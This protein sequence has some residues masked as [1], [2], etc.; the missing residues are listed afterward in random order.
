MNTRLLKKA[1]IIT[2]SLIVLICIASILIMRCSGGNLNAEIIVDGKVLQTV[3]LNSIDAPFTVITATSPETEITVE[4]GAVYFSRSGC[5][6]QLCVKS[7]RLTQKGATA[8]CLP[9]KVVITVS[10]D[11]S[12]D[13]VTY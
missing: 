13:A 4:K 8:V 2:L 7:G 12:V 3:D 9:A 11:K 6:N 10:A 5:E 1:D